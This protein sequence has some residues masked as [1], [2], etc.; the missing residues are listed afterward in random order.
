MGSRGAVPRL[1]AAAGADD[2]TRFPSI[3]QIVNALGGEVSV[4]SIPILLDCTD[5]FLEALL[6]SA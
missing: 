6:R 5:G 3:E 1:G 4:E 2:Q